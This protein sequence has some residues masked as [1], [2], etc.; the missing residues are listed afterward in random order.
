VFSSNILAILGLRSMYFFLANMLQ[1]FDALKYS[2]VIILSFV[3]VK[4]ILTHHV[5]FPEWLSL[6]VIFISLVSGILYSYMKEK[7]QEV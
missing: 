1:K 4:L 5:K 2:L 6:S 7:K 3:G